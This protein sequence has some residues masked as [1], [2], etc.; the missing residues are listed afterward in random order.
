MYR[1]DDAE[2]TA[3]IHL[4]IES[5]SEVYHKHAMPVLGK[6]VKNDYF[7]LHVDNDADHAAMGIALLQD[8]SEQTYLRLEEVVS[9]AWDMV[10]AMTD[11]VVEL[12]RAGAK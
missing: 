5:A 4:V 8:E 6:Y 10:E 7:E 12:T 11:R 1:L 3:I 2:K 9:Q